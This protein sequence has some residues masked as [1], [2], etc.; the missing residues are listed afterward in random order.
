MLNGSIGSF[1]NVGTQ[2]SV[3]FNKAYGFFYNQIFSYKQFTRNWTK[4]KEFPT[5]LILHTASTFL[6]NGPSIYEERP[7]EQVILTL[8]VSRVSPEA[9]QQ[10]QF[11]V[12]ADGQTQ[13]HSYI[14]ELNN[15]RVRLIHLQHP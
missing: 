8:I 2:W 13:I 6:A 15:M 12:N 7:L 5:F 1:T 9:L 11:V 4:N 3:N 14:L 10:A